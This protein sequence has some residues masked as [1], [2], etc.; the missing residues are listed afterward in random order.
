M[1]AGTVLIKYLEQKFGLGWESRFIFRELSQP[2]TFYVRGF[3]DTED[4]SWKNIDM[5]AIV[6]KDK[7]HIT[8]CTNGDVKIVWPFDLNRIEQF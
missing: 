7:K 8:V 5:I 3:Q 1:T 6:D 4:G 2:G